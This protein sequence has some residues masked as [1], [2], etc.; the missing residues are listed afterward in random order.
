[1]SPHSIPWQVGIYSVA[2]EFESI[3]CGGT[4][5][6]DKHVITA[7]HCLFYE[8]DDG[9]D[10]YESMV[11]ALDIFVVVAE[12]NQTDSV[13]GIQHDVRSFTNHPQ[14]NQSAFG[15][16]D[17]SMLHLSLSIEFGDRAIPACLP[18]VR[19]SE[20]KLVGKYL[21]VSGW[22]RTENPDY[23]DNYGYPDLLQSVDVTV[24]SQHECTKAYN[25][26]PPNEITNAMICA[27]HPTGEKDS[28]NGDSGGR[29]WNFLGISFD[30]YHFNFIL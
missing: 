10:F 25:N 18:D 16:Y 24:V 29:F 26:T 9:I 3:H 21:T 23:D 17:F 27:R 14:F 19:F 12:H 1:M 7:A 4:L 13:D 6:T 20:D 5:L 2:N 28:C 11:E 8:N 15:D 22:G 30:S